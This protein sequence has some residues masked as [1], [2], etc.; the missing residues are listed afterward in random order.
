MSAKYAV[1]SN[2]CQ[3]CKGARFIPVYVNTDFGIQ[4]LCES[5]CLACGGSGIRQT[6]IRT[7]PTVAVK[8][9]EQ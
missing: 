7:V 5:P 4:T 1:G 2:I 6:I 8:R 3:R 9:K